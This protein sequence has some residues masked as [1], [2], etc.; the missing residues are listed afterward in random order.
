M[1]LQNN[2]YNRTKLRMFT[3]INKR[4]SK[5]NTYFIGSSCNYFILSS[6]DVYYRM[7]QYIDSI[8]NRFLISNP[9]IVYTIFSHIYLPNINFTT[10]LLRCLLLC[11][12]LCFVHFYVK[13][14]SNSSFKSSYILV[15]GYFKLIPI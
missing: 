2:G 3:I 5:I 10:C 7:V 8:E 12:I 13:F 6:F 11:R 15:I 4:T 9:C 1:V 14:F